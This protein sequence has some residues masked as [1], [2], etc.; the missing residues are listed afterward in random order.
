M[1][2]SGFW[3][4][5]PSILLIVAAPRT[6][7]GPTLMDPGARDAFLA[8]IEAEEVFLESASVTNNS[9]RLSAAGSAAT[10]KAKNLI[11]PLNSP[12]DRRISLPRATKIVT[13]RAASSITSADMPGSQE[14]S[15][16][17]DKSLWNRSSR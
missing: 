11:P 8:S 15:A 17:K 4:L 1:K 6:R 10:L 2:F 3:A 14:T 7:L 13:A 12:S 5:I 9:R 16:S